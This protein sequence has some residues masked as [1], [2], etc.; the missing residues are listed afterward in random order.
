MEINTTAD[1]L[2]EAAR[3]IDE[4]GWCRNTFENSQG[5]VCVRAALDRVAAPVQ[6]RRD[7]AYF[8]TNDLGLEHSGRLAIW[9][10]AAGMTKRKVTSRLR[11]VAKRLRSKTW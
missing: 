1:V 5:H 6:L 3:I 10:D 8:L 4:V 2:D 7:A 9:N 11:K